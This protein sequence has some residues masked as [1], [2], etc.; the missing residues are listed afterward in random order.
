M[1]GFSDLANLSAYRSVTTADSI[2]EPTDTYGPASCKTGN[3]SRSTDQSL[4]EEKHPKKRLFKDI[5]EEASTNLEKICSEEEAN[6][7]LGPCIT[8]DTPNRF[9]SPVVKKEHYEKR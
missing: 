2:I 6:A 1:D 8:S 4:H 3:Q 5:Q 9:D 7:Y